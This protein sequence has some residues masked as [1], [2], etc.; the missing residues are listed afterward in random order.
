MPSTYSLTRLLF[1]LFA[2]DTGIFNQGQFTSAI[3]GYTEEDG[4]DLDQFLSDLF[5]IMNSEPNSELRKT[6]PSH[7]AAFPM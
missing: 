5:A 2:E 1:C 7:L 6:L 4:S 3:K